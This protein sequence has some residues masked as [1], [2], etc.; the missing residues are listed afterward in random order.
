M[1]KKLT[2]AME[3]RRAGRL[4]GRFGGGWDWEVGFQQGGRSLI[5]NLLVFTIRF[6]W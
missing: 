2:I 1:I 4:M 5:L 3:H 6:D